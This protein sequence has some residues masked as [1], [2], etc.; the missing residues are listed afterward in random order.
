MSLVIGADC[1]HRLFIRDKRPKWGGGQ[2][3]PRDKHQVSYRHHHQSPQDAEAAHLL[4][5]QGE[6]VEV[7]YPP[8][9]R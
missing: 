1:L 8:P 7:D 6:G 9:R 2:R 4:H 3:D 5:L